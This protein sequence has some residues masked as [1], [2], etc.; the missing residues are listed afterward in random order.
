MRFLLENKFLGNKTGK[1]LLR[2]NQAKDENGKRL[3][4][5]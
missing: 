1:R 2:K 3:S 5:L 4:M